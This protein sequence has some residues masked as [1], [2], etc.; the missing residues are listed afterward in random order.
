MYTHTFSTKK[1]PAAA[2]RRVSRN[3]AL[4]YSSSVSSHLAFLVSLAAHSADQQ[5]GFKVF[6][7]TAR[8]DTQPKRQQEKRKVKSSVNFQLSAEVTTICQA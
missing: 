2:G 6:K 1:H 7:T 4:C 3:T 8:T 5:P